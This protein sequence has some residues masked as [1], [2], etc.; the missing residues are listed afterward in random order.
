VLTAPEIAKYRCWSAC[1]NS[2]MPLASK[3]EEDW[4]EHGHHSTN[5]PSH[6][7]NQIQRKHRSQLEGLLL[8]LVAADSVRTQSLW[9]KVLLA[10]RG[11]S[12]TRA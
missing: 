12:P 1:V 7:F 10:S 4:R 9:V 2:A 6:G 5:S 11:R 3:P 8:T